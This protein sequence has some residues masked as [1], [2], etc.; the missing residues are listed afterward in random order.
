[1]KRIVTVISLLIATVAIT[2][3]QE[4]NSF[5]LKAGANMSSYLL[6]DMEGESTMKAGLNLGAFWKHD[7]AKSFALQT[8]L[9]FDYQNSEYKLGP[10]GSKY[11]FWT[12]EIPV[13][14]MWQ[15]TTGDNN[16]FY[17]GAGPN[18]SLGLGGKEKLSSSKIFA[19]NAMSRFDVGASVLVGWE[20][21]FGMQVNASYRY[22]FFNA[23]KNPVG[24]ARMTKNC[25]SLGIGYRF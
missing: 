5:G 2:S 24:D 4:K 12:M 20:L 11:S 10:A 3:A 18:L 1:M 9:N 25:V 19:D 15:H 14:A 13:Y 7:F 23:L 8:E 21:P 6:Y 22:G 16:R 17:L